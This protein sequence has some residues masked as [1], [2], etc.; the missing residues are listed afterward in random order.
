MAH[1]VAVFH[2]GRRGGLPLHVAGAVWP[3]CAQGHD[4]VNDPAGAWSARLAGGRARCGALECGDL[5]FA[6]RLFGGGR[7]GGQQRQ[8][9]GYS[10]SCFFDAMATGEPGG[11]SSDDPHDAQTCFL[12]EMRHRE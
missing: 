10:P 7:P 5:G 3:A 1:F 12:A 9:G 8:R 11:T 6:A 4:V 2:F